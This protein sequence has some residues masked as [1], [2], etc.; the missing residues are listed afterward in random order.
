MAEKSSVATNCRET[1]IF[2]VDSGGL[3]TTICIPRGSACPWPVYRLNSQ[4][5][6]TNAERAEY[7]VQNV[8]GGRGSGNFVEWT[9]RAVEIE[10]KHFVRHLIGECGSG[11]RECGERFPHSFPVA[12]IGEESGF[13]LGGCFSTGLLQNFIA[14]FGNPVAGGCGGLHS[15]QLGTEN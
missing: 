1:L 10:Q 4:P 7:Q 15:R 14:Q 5:L 3:G 6:F 12:Q 8:V 13:D 2:T 9:Q 11:G